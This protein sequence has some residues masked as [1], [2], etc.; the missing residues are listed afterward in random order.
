MRVEAVLFDIG[1]VLIT[2]QPERY[3]DRVYGVDGR[4]A[5]FADVDLHW[6]NERLDRGKGSG[7]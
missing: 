2:W 5:L 7:T 1:N 4:K 6:M 3:Y